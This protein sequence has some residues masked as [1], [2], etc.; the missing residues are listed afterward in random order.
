MLFLPD[1]TLLESRAWV[2]LKKATGPWYHL[3]LQERLAALAA[4]Y[5]VQV[6]WTGRDLWESDTL[7]EIINGTGQFPTLKANLLSLI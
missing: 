1:C 5:L 3:E 6:F 7:K 4:G 2:I